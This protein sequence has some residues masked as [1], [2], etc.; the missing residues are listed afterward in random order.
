MA[1]P[2]FRPETYAVDPSALSELAGWVVEGLANRA[3]AL[4]AEWRFS[5]SGCLRF[6]LGS[7]VLRF[8]PKL[9]EQ[10]S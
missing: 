3:Q 2:L 6:W 5:L 4:V 1:W 7:R 8:R 10:E 9:R